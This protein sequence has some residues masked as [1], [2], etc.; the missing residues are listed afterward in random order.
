MRGQKDATNTKDTDTHAATSLS[1]TRPSTY[2]LY[3]SLLTSTYLSTTD[4]ESLFSTT[5]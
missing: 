5:Q 2:K 4:E 1:T 3:L